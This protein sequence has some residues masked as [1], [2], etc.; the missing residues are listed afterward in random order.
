MKESDFMEFDEVV[1]KLYPQ[2]AKG[3]EPEK[4]PWDNKNYT[5]QIKED[6]DRRLLY[7][8]KDGVLNSS[9]S[10]NRSERK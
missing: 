1:G 3:L 10:S 8:T 6:G 2:R 5:W 4:I 7:F 9:K